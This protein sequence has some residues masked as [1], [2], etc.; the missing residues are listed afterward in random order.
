[1]IFLWYEVVKLPKKSKIKPRKK[2]NIKKELDN[3]NIREDVFLKSSFS[4]FEVS[5]ITLIAILFGIVI[6][7]LIN[8]SK[9]A[10][11]NKNLNKI[12][13]TYIIAIIIIF[14]KRND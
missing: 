13:T 6:G 10:S 4:I 14:S 1:M 9:D 2:A 8:Y 11:L 12:I 3:I 7:Y 5:I